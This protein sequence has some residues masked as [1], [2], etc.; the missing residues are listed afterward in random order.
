MGIAYALGAPD[1]SSCSVALAG[2]SGA[3]AVPLDVLD[4]ARIATG[5]HQGTVSWNTL[6][7]T[8][9]QVYSSAAPLDKLSDATEIDAFV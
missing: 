6:L 5:L 8:S 3:T 2:D 1:V 9:I 7:S 4:G